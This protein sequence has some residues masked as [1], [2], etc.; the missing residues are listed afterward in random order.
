V[1]A[2]L[3]GGRYVE[4]ARRA[5]RREDGEGAVLRDTP[6]PKEA[7]ATMAAGGSF[8]VAEPGT[9]GAGGVSLPGLGVPEPVRVHRARV[10]KQLM[11]DQA[12]LTVIIG[13]AITIL[14]YY[15]HSTNFVGTGRELL[16]IFLWA[17]GL[18]VGIQALVAQS[19]RLAAPGAGAG[20]G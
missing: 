13:A 18:D 5:A 1:N 8:L 10:W 17:F 12:L 16:T 7:A 14:G 4:A 20:A 9:V 6:E 15:L 2:L 19:A 11:L 3:A